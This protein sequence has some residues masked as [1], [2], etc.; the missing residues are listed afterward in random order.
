MEQADTASLPVEPPTIVE[1]QLPGTAGPDA[2]TARVLGA[3]RRRTKSAGLVVVA[4]GAA[5][6]AWFLANAPDRSLGTWLGAGY[7][8]LLTL[9]TA[10]LFV[11]HQRGGYDD[12]ASAVVGV[13]AAVGMLYATSWLGI[14]SMAAAPLT[15]LVFYFGL[16]DSPL[17]RRA[18]FVT[19][20]VGFGAIVL[21]VAVGALP[22]T[23]FL[24]PEP[25]AANPDRGYVFEGLFV[26]LLILICYMLARL[27]RRSTLDAM[28]ALERARVRIA[29]Q[30]ALLHEA[31]A[32]FDRAF[33]GARQGRYSGQELGG[34]TIGKVLG[35]GAMGEVYEA[36]D[37]RGEPAAVKVLHAL[38]AESEAHVTRFLREAEVTR[39]LDTPRVP[40]VRGSGR[41]PD[42]APYL[43]MERLV[44]HDLAAVLRERG[45][46]PIAE[47]DALVH[48]VTEGLE[49]AH[50][51]SVVHR[52]VKPQNLFFS[53]DRGW[54]ILDF[55]ISRVLEEGHTLTGAA[56]LGTPSYMAPEQVLSSKV[57]QRADV[58]ALG[59]VL[60]RALT[61][62]PA[63][64]AATPALTM[65]VVHSRQPARPGDLVPLS[66]DV[67]AV[68]ALAL[69]KERD[70]RFSS[71]AELAIAWDAA[72]RG[73]LP[74]SLRSHA[75]ALL[76]R[77]PW[78]ARIEALSPEALER[79]RA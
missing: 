68:L 33:S 30:N 4:L 57:D 63:F 14:G 12:R 75:A 36:E 61:G 69:A 74:A 78:G 25:S 70:D 71:A 15:V 29:Q 21:A 13:L 7:F 20:A 19:A 34:F 55:G 5:F 3:E 40:A 22:P 64:S 11:V 18:A 73:A 27:S 59:A 58:F 39:S 17:R 67:E 16:A 9:V 31:R 35:R 2:L 24:A 54:V 60:Y 65:F 41:A 1:A 50:A 51:A 44:G 43:A 42:G 49:A 56:V 23:G 38:R 66:A 77:Q 62:R 46:L 47:I 26:E 32:N 28:G 53:D 76:R 45:A 79:A 48:D 8:A 52:D 72:R 37:E 10:G 6:A